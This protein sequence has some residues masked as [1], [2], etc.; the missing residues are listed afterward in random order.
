M[1]TRLA[2]VLIAG[3]AASLA[4]GAIVFAATSGGGNPAPRA[5]AGWVALEPSPLQ[6]SEVGAARIRDRIYV[7]GGFLRNGGTTGRM[8]AYD[9]SAGRWLKRRPLPRG[10][11]HPGVAALRGKLYVL[12]GQRG[13]SPQRRV[14]DFWRYAPKRNRWK[15]LPA[16]P[17]P[18]GA[19]ALVGH[20][21][22]LYAVG[23]YSNSNQQLRSLLV[24]D[25][26]RKRW[27]KRAPMPT[28][29]NHL[30]AVWAAGEVWAIGGRRPGGQNLAVV[31]RYD[32]ATNTWQ[33]GPP[34]NVPRSGI[35]ATRVPGSIVV[36]GGEELAEGDST[37][38]EV[39]R[40]DLSD[41]DAGWS[42]LDDMVT[43]RHGLGGAAHKGVVYAL[44]GG[45]QTALTYSNANEALAVP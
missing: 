1:T 8:V 41:V 12:G 28:G 39:E 7:V 15:R 4:G 24:Y 18:R 3:V 35:A 5:G 17:A 22:K 37:I 40:L 42:F 44:E 14:R 19:L 11:N 25:I 43:P 2:R 10:V 36:F 13:R 21:R 20:G 26:R 34:L 45:P 23:G 27:R 31:E 6:R 32:P 33:P 29:R 9:I 16:P 38:P 30:A